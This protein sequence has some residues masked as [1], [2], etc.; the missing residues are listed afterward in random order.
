[1]LRAGVNGVI[2]GRCPVSLKPLINQKPYANVSGPFAK[3]RNS[4]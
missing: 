2:G 3:T 1:M 4:L